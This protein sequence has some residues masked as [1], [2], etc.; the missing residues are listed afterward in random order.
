MESFLNIKSLSVEFRTGE[1]AAKAVEDVSL[2]LRKG[3]TLGLVGES[4]SGKSTMGL[5]IMGLI[6]A[7]GRVTSGRIF[8]EGTDLRELSG[9]GD[10]SNERE[11]DCYDFPRPHDLAESSQEDWAS[12]CRV[13][14][15]PRPSSDEKQS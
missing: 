12:L 15:S 3:E 7:P 13:H 10:A 9:D 2:E 5:A 11:K 14:P 1:G 4:G 8:F 6:Q